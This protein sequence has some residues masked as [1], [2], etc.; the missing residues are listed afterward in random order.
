MIV[1]EPVS[2]LDQYGAL[3]KRVLL[4][5]AVAGSIAVRCSAA[6]CPVCEARCDY[7]ARHYVKLWLLCAKRDG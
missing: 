4:Q 7:W 1:I 6:P 5:L 3:L 2:A